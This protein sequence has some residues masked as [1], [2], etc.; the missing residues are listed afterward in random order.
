MHGNDQEKYRAKWGRAGTNFS[1]KPIQLEGVDDIFMQT[2]DFDQAIQQQ[3]LEAHFQPLVD[4]HSGKITA[5]EA[6]VR[7]N[8]GVGQ[9]ITAAG[10]LRAAQEADVG[11]LLDHAVLELAVAAMGRLTA[12]A[13]PALPVAV[14]ISA[15]TCTNEASAAK[16][17]DFLT[18]AGVKPG[19][20]RLEFPCEALSNAPGTLVPLLQRLAAKDHAVAIDHVASA[21]FKAAHLDAIPAQA[22]KLDEALV[23]QAPGDAASAE[24]VRE[25][26]LAAQKQSLQVGVEGVVRLEQLEFLRQ[27]GCHEG[28]GPLISR[29]LPLGQL[30]FLLKKGRCW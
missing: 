22:I 25:I 3:Q 10:V 5:I 2:I 1:F 4:L 8:R 11:W 27:A 15:A 17:E 30:I 28:Q 26:C 9:Q 7:W 20:L 18:R 16:L 21:D 23:T 19:R 14:N 12:Q 6:R 24:R 29:P 13:A